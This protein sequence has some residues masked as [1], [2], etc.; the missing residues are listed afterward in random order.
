MMGIK[1]W[2]FV[3][4]LSIIAAACDS[5]ANEQALLQGKLTGEEATSV[6]SVYLLNR[7]EDSSY[8][9]IAAT[10]VAKDG[11]FSLNATPKDGM[12]YVQAP[13]DGN[14]GSD[15]PYVVVY[16][17]KGDKLTGTFNMADFA[18]TIVEGSE[19]SE[20]SMSVV[21]EKGTKEFISRSMEL[22]DE[23]RLIQSEIKNGK[24]TAEQ[25]AKLDENDKNF[26]AVNNEG[27]TYDIE[28]LKQHPSALVSVEVLAGL[29]Y[30]ISTD[31]LR[32]GLDQLTGIAKASDSYARL[33]KRY[34]S[35]VKTAEGQAVVDFTMKTPEGK[36]FSTASLKSKVFLIDF[37]A[38]WC[39]PCRQ[40]NPHVIKMYKELHQKGFEVVG[41]SLDSKQE[42]WEK[43]I[44]KDGLT[45]HQV[46]DLKGW[47]NEA[48]QLYNVNFIPETV[49]VD[50]EGKIVA[51]GLRGEE[52]EAKVKEVLAAK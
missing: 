22:R 5:G 32:A 16:Y 45:W 51:R 31:E 46:S 17:R 27:K 2:A 50:R 52:L 9:R 25:Q 34:N 37:W 15:K 40:E 4:G 12:Y 41:V 38:S 49:L 33:E 35:M 23:Y 18:K 43:A 42:S 14:F 28:F 47:R 39:G 7:K 10:A 29:S 6:D 1:K 13:T 19:G 21:Y 8:E 30:T 26:E 36:D 44:A 20:Q 3:I 11:T 24:P 48:A